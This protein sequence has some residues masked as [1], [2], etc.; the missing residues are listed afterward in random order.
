MGLDTSSQFL[1]VTSDDDGVTWSAPENWT[2]ALKDPSWYLFAPAPGNGITLKDGTLVMPTQGRDAKGHPFSNITWSKDHGKTWMV[3]QPAR[4]NTTECAVAPLADGRLLLN[5]RDNRNRSNKGDTN[6]RAMGVTADLGKTWSVHSADHGALPEPVCMASMI[7]WVDPKTKQ[8]WLFFSNPR[9]KHRRRMMTI[10]ASS[11]GGKTWPVSRHV[12]LDE[13]GGMYSS[14]V[15]VDDETVGI[16]YESSQSNLVF[17]R[18]PVA[19]LIEGS[20]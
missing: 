18:I 15:M 9:D 12:L 7:A 10:Q 8:H 20:E 2:A 11:D 1:V 4:D 16:V 17:Q 5:M 14:L 19:E 13:R 3:S 6:G